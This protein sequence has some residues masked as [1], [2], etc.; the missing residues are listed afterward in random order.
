M[1]SKLARHVDVE[2]G[3][4]VTGVADTGS[5]VL[6]TWT[7]RDGIERIDEASAVVIAV[8]APVMLELCPHLA[9]EARAILGAVE[10]SRSISVSRGIRAASLLIMIAGGV[11]LPFCAAVSHELRRIARWPTALAA[12]QLAGGAVNA[13]LF[14]LLGLFSMVA[15]ACRPLEG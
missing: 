12:A 5:G 14:I 10:Y 7:D 15:A 11:Y 1:S 4:R 13:M 3:A 2:L 6:V 8:P 9:G